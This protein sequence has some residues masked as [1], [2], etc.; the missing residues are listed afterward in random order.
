MLVGKQLGRYEIRQR[1]G[2]GGMGEVYLAHDSQLDRD[3]ALKILSSEF[4]TDE[5]RRSRF[6]QE[7]RA[8][9]ALNHPNIITIYEIGE[10]EHG[11]FIV[12][13]HIDGNT[14]RDVLKHEP[15]SI[16]RILKIAEQV[17]NALVAAHNAHIIHRDIKP[18]NIM[19]RRDGIAKVLDFGLAKPIVPEDAEDGDNDVIKTIPGMVMGSARYMSP[20]Q[21]RG[22]KVDERTDIWSLGIVLYEMLAGTSPFSGATTTDTIAEVIY[23]EPEP[24]TKYVH[25]APS[26][27][28]RIIRRTLK[29]DLD[30]RY[31]SIKDFA[32]DLKNLI[33]ELE[34]ESS[35]E[36]MRAVSTDF[37]MSENP[38]MIHQT[39]SISNPTKA[40]LP[41]PS[42]EYTI[43]NT[44]KRRV[45]IALASLGV[46]LL[47]AVLGFGYFRWFGGS[48]NLAANA[49]DKTQVSRLNSDGKVTLP[50]ISP[51]GKY[52]A[53]IS[54]DVGNRSLV[55]REISTESMVTVVQPTNLG[56]SAIA[57]SPSG[58]YIYYCQ[59]RSDFSVNTLYQVAKLGGTPKKL[60]E[61]V[62]SAVTFSPD[63]KQFAFIRHTSNTNEDLVF[64]VDANTL[65]LQK[66]ISSKDTEFDFFTARPAWSPDGEKILIGAGKRQGGF[67]SGT[68]V[69][70][71][72]IAEKKLRPVKTRDWFVVGSFIWF[73][74]GSGFLFVA[75][76]MQNSPL[77][78]WR[79][80]Y[81][82]GEVHAVT[83][84]FNDYT[85]IGL[86][87]DGSSIITIKGD[88]VSSLWRFSPA[89]KENAQLT[90]DS[91]NLEGNAG[92]GQMPD[93][94]L[95]YTRNEG[96]EFDF[97]LSDADGK[98]AR[99]LATDL[100][101]VFNPTPTS[102]GRYIIYNTQ[103]PKVARI[104]RMDADGKNATRL[105]DESPNHADFNPTVMPDGK[106]I[107]FQRLDA[108]NNRSSLM[109][110]SVDGGQAVPF[111]SDGKLNTFNPKIS[112]DG[113]RI[114]FSTYDIDSF[115]RKLRVASLNGDSFGQ[116]EKDLKS[117]LI[118]FYD[119]SP[120][121]KT[122][123]I[124]TNQSGVPNLMRLPVDGAADPQPI[125]DF[126]SGRI[127]NFA[128]SR[129]G[130]NI[131]IVRGIVNSDL[132]L[133]QDATRQQ[134]K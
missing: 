75:R 55:V 128:W 91:R 20:E 133:I 51:D 118:N 2:V 39:S 120:D 97:W 45:Q 98:N 112:P 40:V 121:S 52:I 35:G 116:V 95:I 34:H 33:Y 23:K 96:K 82:G 106:T 100:G 16:I 18:E 57:F 36:K 46:V 15:L 77:Q 28:Q 105:T 53:Y 32:I 41:A 81:P 111:Y 42:V 58:D 76:E 93:G 9:S 59:T 94:K 131:F 3:V 29:K 6:R 11:S 49:F 126:K 64:I 65:N 124:S 80:T 99:S 5:S 1:L 10:G 84:D 50:T 109:K 90:G 78:I 123:T 69:A 67:V 134:A 17:A 79:S 19:V 70:E 119:W 125:T 104:W 132:I 88:A 102:D 14:L 107:I 37:D 63:G 66:L 92:L 7:A 129:D 73:K 85:E 21:A 60:V 74:D 4:S 30:E 117:N 87:E 115:E 24:I 86:S 54:G 13:E 31:Q 26:E 25:N 83:N 122:L 56:F 127:F 113:K 22:Q 12:T 130:K 101:L 47:L 68:T 72:S 71:I 114:V 8:V 27:L 108:S 110:I 61:D 62:D 44:R 48:K 103:N 43:E 89:T 38:T